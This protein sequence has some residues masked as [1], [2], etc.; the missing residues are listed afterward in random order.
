MK[1]GHRIFFS[2]L[3][4]V[5]AVFLFVFLEI[6]K[7]SI[8]EN[9]LIRVLDKDKEPV[10]N[11]SCKADIITEE[12]SVENVVL[13]EVADLSKFSPGITPSGKNPD[14][15]FYYLETGMKDYFG[16]FEIKIVCV[17]PKFEGVS[18]TILNNTYMPCE[19][20]KN[21]DGSDFVIC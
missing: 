2:L 15:G 9:V 6:P 5:L 11:A 20:K 3:F 10:V 14:K 21:Q 16:N 8:P 13:R 19:V 4:L 7:R 12:R 17:S 18:Y 1:M